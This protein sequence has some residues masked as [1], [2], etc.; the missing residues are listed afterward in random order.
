M[1]D[2]FIQQTFVDLLWAALRHS[3]REEF[4]GQTAQASNILA[5][6]KKFTCSPVKCTPVGHGFSGHR[7]IE[8]L[9][10]EWKKPLSRSWFSLCGCVLAPALGQPVYD[11]NESL[12]TSEVL[13]A[14]NGIYH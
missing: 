9:M 6:R 2:A 4:K 1:L 8:Q 10:C 11:S 3:L 5:V 13:I 7:S 12:F 14:K